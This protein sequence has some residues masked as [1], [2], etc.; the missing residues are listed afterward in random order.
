MLE[1]SGYEHICCTVSPK[2]PVSLNNLL[3]YKN[4]PMTGAGIAATGDE[5]AIICL[6][7]ECQRE[8]IQRGY[9]GYRVEGNEERSEIFYR[10]KSIPAMD[11]SSR[12]IP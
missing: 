12:I 3:S 1:S 9:E 10:K 4:W 8:L 11:N 6:N 7:I 5:T 2:N